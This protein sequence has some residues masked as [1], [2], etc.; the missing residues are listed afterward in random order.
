MTQQSDWQEMTEK[1]IAA[2]NRVKDIRDNEQVKFIRA[3]AD[4]IYKMMTGEYNESDIKEWANF[5]DSWIGY[6]EINLKDEPETVFT[7]MFLSYLEEDEF[8]IKRLVKEAE[9]YKD[10]SENDE[11][12]DKVCELVY[13]SGVRNGQI[14]AQEFSADMFTVN[15]V[16][17][18][19]I[20]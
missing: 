17:T 20:E 18:A 14:N 15:C 10:G 19:D 2:E 6:I 4:Q 16:G 7:R 13:L 5:D 9:L 8:H 11:I 3:W 1:Q 12:M